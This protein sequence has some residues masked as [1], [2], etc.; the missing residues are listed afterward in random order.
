MMKTKRQLCFVI[1]TDHFSDDNDK[2]LTIERWQVDLLLNE[3]DLRYDKTIQHKLPSRHISHIMVA[4]ASK[5]TGV[6]CPRTSRNCVSE[7]LKYCFSNTQAESYAC[8]TRNATL[9][10]TTTVDYKMTYKN[11]YKKYTKCKVLSFYKLNIVRYMRP[12]RLF[13][14]LIFLFCNKCF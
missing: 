11:E 14:I 10:K 4:I 12:N 7:N 5:I 8:I 6:L 2:L 3:F 1:S 13:L 9:Q